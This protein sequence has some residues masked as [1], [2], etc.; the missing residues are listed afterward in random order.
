M[1]FVVNWSH[2]TMKNIVKIHFFTVYFCV[3]QADLEAHALKRSV[4]G[5][6]DVDVMKLYV[7]CDLKQ[8]V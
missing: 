8:E 3:L 5:I 7:R 2:D 1:V 6:P 4:A